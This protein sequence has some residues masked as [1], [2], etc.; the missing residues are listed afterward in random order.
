[1]LHSMQVTMHHH[2]LAPACWMIN[3]GQ[4]DK[5]ALRE[6]QLHATQSDVLF[7]SLR[8][9]YC[10]AKSMGEDLQKKEEWSMSA[11]RPFA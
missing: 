1:M 2:A 4:D 9:T 7:A 5:A 6:Y 8:H 3:A 10:F 11:K